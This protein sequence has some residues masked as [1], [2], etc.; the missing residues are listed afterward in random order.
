MGGGSAPTPFDQI[1]ASR[2]KRVGLKPLP[3]ETSRFN[4]ARDHARAAFARTR[5]QSPSV[6]TNFS[7]PSE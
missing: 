1:A 3:Q 4:A 6:L 2:R 7:E 5:N